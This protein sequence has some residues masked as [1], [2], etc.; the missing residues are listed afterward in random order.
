MLFRS[1][2]LSHYMLQSEQLDTRLVLAANDETAAGLLVQRMPLSGS[3][4]LG[5]GDDEQH[6]GRN[7]DFN[8]IALLA[9]TLGAAELLALPPGEVLRR[10]WRDF[11]KG[12]YEWIRSQ[13][14]AKGIA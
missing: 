1:D 6:I 8:R 10:R 4:N 2:V 14:R 12:N 7:E 11:F 13:A 5:G 3:G 9:G